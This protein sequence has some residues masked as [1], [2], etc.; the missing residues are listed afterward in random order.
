MGIF[1]VHMDCFP[2]CTY[3][4]YTLYLFH[5]NDAYCN[6]YVVLVGIHVKTGLPSMWPN[7]IIFCLQASEHSLYILLARCFYKIYYTP[8]MWCQLSTRAKGNK[9][10]KDMQGRLHRWKLCYYREQNSCNLNGKN[11]IMNIFKTRTTLWFPH[12]LYNCIHTVA[13]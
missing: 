8:S 2:G 11:Y 12:I 6:Y 10:K 7:W 4:Y 1:S 13:I 5:I 3:Y 9:L